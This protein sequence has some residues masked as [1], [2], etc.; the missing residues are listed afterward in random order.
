MNI[1]KNTLYILTVLLL[2]NCNNAT[3]EH[4]HSEEDDH[5]HNENIVSHTLFSD[6]YQIYVE[7]PQ[8]VKGEIS[9]FKTHVTQ[10]SDFKPLEKDSLTVKLIGKKTG[11]KHTA[12]E[13]T[14][15][16][17]FVPSLQPKESGKF[18]LVFEF[19]LDNRLE[20]FEV[21]NVEVIDDHELENVTS[22]SSENEISFLLEQAWKTDFAITKLKKQNFNEVIETSGQLL[23]AN[24]DEVTIV[25]PFA[26]IVQ[27]QS[28]LIEG[29][30]VT[31]GDQLLVLTGK[32]LASE[33]ISVHY[34]QLK[35]NYTKAKANFERIAKLV[36]DKIVSDK[37]FIEAKTEYEQ[38][39]VAYENVSTTGNGKVKA[40]LNGYIKNVFVSEGQFV[41]AGTPLVKVSQNQKLI[42]R[43]DVSHNHWHCLPSITEANFLTSYDNIVHNTREHAG[44]L[45]SYGRTAS[46]SA[47]STPL[48]FEIENIDNL[49]P[50]SY[51]EVF[52]LSKTIPNV[53]AVPKNALI[54]EQDHYFVFVQLSGESYEKREVK[55]GISNGSEIEIVSGLSE[56]EVV[57]TK[58]AYQVKLASMSSVLPAHNHAH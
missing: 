41:E 30:K 56:G 4:D 37:T 6:N 15:P 10:L 9:E 54:E 13:V 12:H 47:W 1:I 52:L 20:K 25:A 28:Y 2:F 5:V 17:I 22:S 18:R 19:Y 44:K 58:G 43:A 55:K 34:N 57:V 16:G 31:K 45:I 32:G 49:I 3:D 53:I 35:T 40:N 14:R 21:P 26:G 11:I 7:Y 51:I 27:M 42:L 38:A 48:Y 39:K 8:L 24:E 29:K 36:D 46:N 50:G 33:N 23:S